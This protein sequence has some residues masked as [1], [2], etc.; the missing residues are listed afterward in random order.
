MSKNRT[1]AKTK[2]RAQCARVLLL[3]QVLCLLSGLTVGAGQA[4]A[5]GEAD[6]MTTLRSPLIPGVPD[7][8]AYS[9]PYEGQPPPIGDGFNPPPVTPGHLG[10]PCPPPSAVYVPPVDG[11]QRDLVDSYVAPY[12]TPPPSTPGSDWGNI[13]GWGGGTGCPAPA[14]VV[15]INPTGGI[16]GSAP[17]ERWNAQRS[18]DHGRNRNAANGNASNAFDFGDKPVDK[19]DVKLAPQCSQDGPRKG[20][21]SS[22]DGPVR[23]PNIPDAQATAIRYGNRI[24]SKTGQKSKFTIAPY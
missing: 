20:L 17:T 12:L 7:A 14:S 2:G 1:S 5:Y 21:S 23:C 10:G 24:I 22:M 6:V 19:P 9:M 15:N 8:P 3:S 18:F 4:G 16:F 13:N 11:S